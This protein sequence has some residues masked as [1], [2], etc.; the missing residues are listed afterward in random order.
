MGDTQDKDVVSATNLSDTE[1]KLPAAA[2]ASGNL[3][4]TLPRRQRT[5]WPRARI[6]LIVG[7]IALGM[8]GSA[9]WWTHVQPALPPGIVFGNGRIEADPIDI[10]TKFA[11]RIQELRV[12]EGDMVKA[13]QI[14]AIMDTRDLA[15]SLKKSEALVEQAQKAI[16]E[17]RANVDLQRS[18]VA[19]ANQEM[20][21]AT[22]LLAKGWIT[23]ETFD[24]R[25]QA[26][27]GA[28]AAQIGAE[29]RVTEV[30]H[31]LDA[32]KH[33]VELYS[34]NIA[35]NTLVAPRDGR[36]EYRIANVGE[37]LSAGGK[38][39][40]MLDISYVYMDIYLPTL[41]ADRVKVGDEARILLDAFPDRPIP[42][43][44]K[45]IASQAQF[46]PK[47]VETQTERDKLMF[48][49]RVRVDPVLSRAH[50]GAVR[51]GLPGAAYV[52]FDPHAHWP[53]RLLGTS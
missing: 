49:I 32:A 16:N 2:T 1:A 41:S 33:D 52:K 11:G 13:G 40:T 20:E 23:K 51:S 43:N 10:A 15:A 31:G 8:G 39:F 27:D 4:T 42:A 30:E 36:I 37:V 35:D 5:A 28:K 45:F 21:R 46:T 7:A 29:A 47:M 24:Q 12:D 53:E 34:V 18:Q 17:A 38:V 26:L 9:Y 22:A 48:R 3:P 6:A 19:L 14:V 44:V 50:A 25:R